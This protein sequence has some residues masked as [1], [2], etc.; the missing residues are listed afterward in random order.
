MEKKRILIVDDE[1]LIADQLAAFL[2]S[3][4]Y[5]TMR[6]GSGEKTIRML[7]DG[8]HPDLILMD[9]DLGRGR[10]DGT[11]TAR[12][13]YQ[14][15]DVPV[16]F[17]SCHSDEATIN[18]TKS[19]SK[20]GIID[21]VPGNEVF[22]LATIEMA[23]SLHEANRKLRESEERFRSLFENSALGIYR[24][25]PGG[26]ILLANVTLVRM[27]GYESFEELA[28]RNLEEN[29]FEPS[30]PREQF[31]RIIE[32][33]G[34]VRGLESAWKR[35][36]GKI[37][38][39]RESAKAVRDG[40]SGT[41]AFYEGTVEDITGKKQVK[42][43]IQKAL[44]EK[45]LLLR[46]LQHRIKNNMAV[47]SSLLSLEMRSTSN[48]ETVRVFSEARGRIKSM[49]QIY[50]TLSRSDNLKSVDFREYIQSLVKELFKSYNVH[51]RVKLD[52]QV[53]DVHIDLKKAIPC[54]LIM[55]EL[56]SNALKY[57]FPKGRPGKVGIVLQKKGR[58][59]VEMIVRDDGVGF[60]IPFNRKNPKTMGLR[61]VWMMVDQIDGH[62]SVIKGKGTG[63][64]ITFP[65]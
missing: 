22:L 15:C 17:H 7:E 8:F 33:D 43:Q 36:D 46:E 54:G 14:I 24:T 55:N 44:A 65:A 60:T 5:A 11:E 45:D 28:T 48:P 31:R 29:G 20:Y 3:R 38:Y 10:M 21:K 59:Q 18:K 12:R 58:N 2:E 4:G 49:T 56:I 32:R 39:V 27:L 41:A 16:V 25:T 62:L 64:R 23:F 40:T 42:E 35:R 37:I 53:D 13:V 1:V 26:R 63:F 9:I 34:E 51:S 47:I 50:D 57:A 52:I 19:V 30:Y 6:T 61:I